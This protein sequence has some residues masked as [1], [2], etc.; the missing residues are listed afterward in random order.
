MN[1]RITRSGRLRAGQSAGVNAART[2][3][4]ILAT[5]LAGQARAQGPADARDERQMDVGFDV[6]GV[7]DSDALRGDTI[8]NVR[9]DAV[10]GDFLLSPRVTADIVAPIGRQ[11]AFLNGQV[12]YVFHQNNRFL[13]REAINGEGGVRVRAIKGCVATLTGRYTQQQSN[14][15]DIVDGLDPTN[16]EKIGGVSADIGCRSASGLAPSLSVGRTRAKN[17]SLVRQVNEYVNDNAM[18]SLGY[19]RPQLGT[20]SV[21][22][23]AAKSRYPLR[24]AFLPGFPADGANV[25]S[26]GF[27]YERQIGTRLSG[28]VSLGYTRV[29][30]RLAGTPDFKGASWDVDLTYDSRNRFRGSLSFARSVE[31]S[32]LLGDT[33]GI[34]TSL[35]VNGDYAFSDRFRLTA[36]AAYVRRKQQQSPL[37]QLPNFNSRDRTISVYSRLTAGNV[38]P[39]GIAFDVSHEHRKSVVPIFNYG[40][41][42]FG[43]TAT[44]RWGRGR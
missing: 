44:F 6:S 5:F 11:S 41:T 31:Q 14:L 2:G 17:S 16:V 27:G 39:V 19:S 28:K 40:S 34:N 7:Y 24:R 20:V 15:F 18:A 21:Y 3:I 26:A 38:G 9:P 30:P 32:N 29:D 8:R 33:Y 42:R 37:F 43:V 1:S 23:S 22:V 4:A 10:N 36:G 35:R 12:G 13:N 25:Y